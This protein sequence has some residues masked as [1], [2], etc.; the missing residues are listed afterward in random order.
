MEKTLSSNFKKSRS[1]LRLTQKAM[2]DKLGVSLKSY[3]AYEEDRACPTAYGLVEMSGI[4]GISDVVAFLTDPDFNIEDLDR[5]PEI[6][7][8]GEL[9][10]RH[11]CIA[12]LKIKL[13]VNILLGLVDLD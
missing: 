1:T 5:R 7:K 11:Y 12:P 2:A 4:L 13:A 10:Q 8:N 6:V 3:Q 9:L